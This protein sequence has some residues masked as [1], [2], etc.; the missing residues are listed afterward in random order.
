MKREIRITSDGSH[1]LYAPE[2]DEHYHSIHG[3]IQESSHVFINNGI[4]SLFGSEIRVLEVGF[5]TGLNALL[6]SLWSKK[7]NIF[8]D[9]TG[10]EAFP[11]ELI[12]NKSLNYPVLI[13]FV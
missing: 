1:T 9:Y 13:L 2:I 3:A 4:H 12:V 7:H 6:T 10:V 5:G 8:V 11:V